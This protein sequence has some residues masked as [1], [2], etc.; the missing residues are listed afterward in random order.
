MAAGKVK[1]RIAEHRAV[2][3]DG[4]LRYA[5]ELVSVPADEA[6]VL[7]AEGYAEKPTRAAKLRL[8]LKP[9]RRP[10]RKPL[11]IEE[12]DPTLMERG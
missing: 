9:K 12:D 5:G 2:Q 4:V 3:F 8:S 10:K 7:I 1:V 6:R 11:V